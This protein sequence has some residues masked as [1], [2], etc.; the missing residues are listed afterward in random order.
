MPLIEVRAPTSTTR[1]AAPRR[2]TQGDDQ[3]YNDLASFAVRGGASSLSACRTLLFHF[4]NVQYERVPRTVVR[5]RSLWEA[6]DE[7]FALR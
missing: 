3:H 4:W 1:A 6:P 2:T 5:L 7:G